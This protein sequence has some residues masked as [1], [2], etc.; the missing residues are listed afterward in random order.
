MVGHCWRCLESSWTISRPRMPVAPTTIAAG[1]SD[2]SSVEGDGVVFE[3]RRENG[4]FMASCYDG[5]VLRVRDVNAHHHI[6]NA[7]CGFVAEK[8]CNGSRKRVPMM[9][10]LGDYV[11]KLVC[12][13]TI[14]GRSYAPVAPS[15]MLDSAICQFHSRV[16]HL[17]YACS[18]L[19]SQ[20][21]TFQNADLSAAQPCVVASERSH[22]VSHRLTR[23][24]YRAE[25]SRAE[26]GIQPSVIARVE[27]VSI[28]WTA[29]FRGSRFCHVRS[30]NW[31]LTSSLK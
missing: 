13:P 19:S 8:C 2:L 11:L 25:T 6:I 20:V 3:K 12:K 24:S 21:V 28:R 26:D 27:C 15:L 18:F 17:R 7:M 10:K 1:M 9:Y 30:L 16:A 14:T 23:R 31:D 22:E 4:V 29:H 5:A